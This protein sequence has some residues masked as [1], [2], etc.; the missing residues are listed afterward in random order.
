MRRIHSHATSEKYRS[1]TQ[2]STEI[3]PRIPTRLVAG[4][5]G[6]SLLVSGYLFVTDVSDTNAESSNPLRNFR[7]L[8]SDCIPTETLELTDQ[9]QQQAEALECKAVYEDMDVAIVNYAL[10]E[11]AAEAIAK[12]LEAR[13]ED[14]T[15]RVMNLEVTVITPSDEA[16]ALHAQES[17]DNCIDY[18]KEADYGSYIANAVMPELNAYD[19]IVGLEAMPSCN[20]TV[21]GV[22]SGG[23][24][25]YA[26]AFN[27]SD[28]SNP[29]IVT[30]IA[31][32]ELLHLYGI[33]HSGALHN[34]DTDISDW[35]QRR[36]SQHITSLDIP[37]YV[38]GGSYAEYQSAEVMGYPTDTPEYD[39][40]NPIHISELLWPFRELDTENFY[41]ET[42]NLANGDV[43]FYRGTSFTTIA[44]LDISA[45]FDLPTS[46]DGISDHG[47][48]H[49]KASQLAFTPVY[50]E[51]GN[52]I[53]G[54]KVQLVTDDNSVI[55]LGGVYVP[56][57]EKSAHYEFVVGEQ[58]VTV[59]LNHDSAFITAG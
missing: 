1:Y 31:A 18:T 43:S 55:S 41:D 24:Y 50:F 26:E 38:A 19:S 58:T 40:L 9:A 56:V 37:T 11:D 21:G 36:E 27:V 49:K 3:A 30:T 22:A 45:P 52:D 6:L 39:K 35:F 20:E 47:E 10:D 53:A 51:N 14:M 46:T 12:S 15:A 54:V 23:H 44:S 5:G 25:R 17:P 34:E 29:A 2:R 42:K 7:S 8:S 59:N 4:L 16:I 28:E 32:H 13:V 48:T 33:G 57:N